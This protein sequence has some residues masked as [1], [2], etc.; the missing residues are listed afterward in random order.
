MITAFILSHQVEREVM[1]FVH[2]M[3]QLLANFTLRRKLLHTSIYTRFRANVAMAA[4]FMA[5]LT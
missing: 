2:K 3:P 1:M 4:G 5:M